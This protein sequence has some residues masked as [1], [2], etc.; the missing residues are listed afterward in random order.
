M[1]YKIIVARYQEDISWLNPIMDDCV[2]INKGEPLNIP[3]EVITE[4][5]GR[6]SHSY[7]KFIIDNYD[8]LPDINIFTQGNIEDHRGT[9]SIPYL[10][11]LGK[12]AHIYGKSLPITR[13]ESIYCS[14]VDSESYSNSNVWNFKISRKYDSA[15]DPAWNYNKKTNKWYLEDNYLNNIP[16]KF[17]EW[18]TQNIR[19]DYPNPIYIYNH[20]IFAVHRNIILKHP[21]SYYEELSKQVDHH[22]NSTEGHFFERSWFYIFE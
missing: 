16:I 11:E 19:K 6:E 15:F 9:N 8:S 2:I 20:A 12:Q 17:I 14:K 7:L 13:H 21:K 22:I 1:S 18:F 10:F 3:N 4:N 5:V